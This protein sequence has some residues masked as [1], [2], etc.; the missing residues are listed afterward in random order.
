MSQFAS[1]AVAPR[2]I[3]WILTPGAWEHLESV[4]KRNCVLVGGYFSVLVPLGPSGVPSAEYVAY[5]SDYDP[6][7][8]I[9]P[10]SM[11]VAAAKD[12]CVGVYPFAWVPWEAASEVVPL[13]PW[14]AR[15]RLGAAPDPDMLRR[16]AP[17][18]WTSVA[19]SDPTA[20]SESRLALLACGDTDDTGGALSWAGHLRT[21]FLVRIIERRIPTAR[22]AELPT[23]ESSEG[24]PVTPWYLFPVSGTTAVLDATLRLQRFPTNGSSLIGFTADYWQVSTPPLRPWSRDTPALPDMAIL[25]SDSLSVED[26][27]LFW[28]LRAC[29]VYVAWLPLHVLEHSLDEVGWWLVSEAPNYCFWP[30]RPDRSVDIAFSAPAD[31]RERLANVLTALTSVSCDAAASARTPPARV[32]SVP[33]E[34]LVRYRGWPPALWQEHTLV[35][36]DGASC[37]FVPRFTQRG[38]GGIRV[39]ELQWDGCML[40]RSPA[41][42]RE[43]VAARTVADLVPWAMPPDG[44]GNAALALPQFRV[45]RDRYLRIQVTSESPVDFERPTASEVFAALFRGAGF[46]DLRESSAAGYQRDLIDRVGGLAIA[47]QYLGGQPTRDLL[48]LLTDTKDRQKPGWVVERPE[49][50]RVLHHLDLRKALGWVTEACTAAYFAKDCDALPEVAAALLAQG[51]LERGVL[52]TCEKCRYKSWYPVAAISD[53]FTCGRC[54]ATQVYGTNPP[55]LYKLA[56]V[57]YQGLAE[58]MHVP[59]LALECLRRR[60]QQSSFE[61]AYDSDV[62]WSSKA[63]TVHRNVDLLVL[64]DGRALVG[65]AK[66]CNTIGSEQFDFYEQLCQ[67][68]DL[69]GV[70]F[71][72]SVPEWCHATRQSIERLQQSSR[73]EVISL[74]ERDLYR[75]WRG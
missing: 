41:V 21:S 62:Y 27:A 6:D 43:C 37:S 70:V 24:S 48:H 16:V 11:S 14:P 42:T 23:V 7:L 73:R 35:A 39:A 20:P 3:A 31:S 1:C 25:V 55:W 65:E 18:P 29:R 49:R 10:P 32:G 5:L 8:V 50:R 53:T 2:K 59:I 34:Q 33:T 36:T 51:V 22:E 19:V 38:Y 26:A 71:A 61:L 54:Y 56:E 58:D 74:V 44:T 72:T 67:R 57:V 45:G 68:V 60:S 63:K 4:V 66:S 13:D 75:P 52:L 17:P 46:V 30:G 40:P 15:D 47:A 28:N 69:D 9:L 64:V 12:A